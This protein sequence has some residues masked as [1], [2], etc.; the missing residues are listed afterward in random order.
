MGK[1]FEQQNSL[2]GTWEVW[3]PPSNTHARTQMTLLFVDFIEKTLILFS[4]WKAQIM[5]KRREK[6]IAQSP[7]EI[8]KKIQRPVA[9]DGDLDWGPWDEVLGSI[10]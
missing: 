2:R 1:G 6:Q 3:D 4:L 9:H 8:F 5:E 10:F 7:G